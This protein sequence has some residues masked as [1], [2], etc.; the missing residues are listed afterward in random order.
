MFDFG[1]V[2][3]NTWTTDIMITDRIQNKH[4]PN[5][6]RDYLEFGARFILR[7]IYVEI[8]YV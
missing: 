3:H 4:H 7:C 2:V 6:K 5:L 8:I 1:L